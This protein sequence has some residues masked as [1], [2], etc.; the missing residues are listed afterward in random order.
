[1]ADEPK[2]FEDLMLMRETSNQGWF[3]G[4]IRNESLH[5][6]GEAIE[7]GMLSNRQVV[8]IPWYDQVV[9]KEK[10]HIYD[11]PCDTGGWALK[12]QSRTLAKFDSMEDFKNSEWWTD[13]MEQWKDGDTDASWK[14]YV[15]VDEEKIERDSSFRE[16]ASFS[17]E[18]GNMYRD[19]LGNNRI[20]KGHRK[21]EVWVDRSDGGLS[22][23]LEDEDFHTDLDEL[24]EMFRIYDKLKSAGI[25]VED[26]EIRIPMKSA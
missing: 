7:P 12:I 13:T 1:M 4:Q 10:T 8:V 11:H 15:L 5:E 3:D 22:F 14:N 21:F 19:W 6:G 18:V 20:G 2:T 26:D 24:A 17:C 9:V 25:T 16:E 23:Y